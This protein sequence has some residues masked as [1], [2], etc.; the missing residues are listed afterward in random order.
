VTTTVLPNTTFPSSAEIVTKI[1]DP[2]KWIADY[3]TGN[4]YRIPS[5]SGP[6]SGVFGGSGT[7]GYVGTQA[8]LMGD[9][10]VDSYSNMIRNAVHPGEQY[11][12]KLNMMSMVSNDIQTVNIPGLT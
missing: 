8:W 6:T 5:Q 12:T 4:Q 9:G 11:F 3:K 7:N 1:T 2:I 10:I